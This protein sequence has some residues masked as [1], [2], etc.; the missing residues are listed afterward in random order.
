[1]KSSNAET[2]LILFYFRNAET[3]PSNRSLSFIW[4]NIARVDD[5][6]DK[7]ILALF[8]IDRAF[9]SWNIA[10]LPSNLASQEEDSYGIR[11]E[12]K[13]SDRHRKSVGLQG[14]VAR[15]TCWPEVD[16]VS[17]AIRLYRGYP[18]LSA[19]GLYQLARWMYALLGSSA[20]SYAGFEALD[21]LLSLAVVYEIFSHTFRDFEGLRKLTRAIFLWVA[22]VLA[23][24]GTAV[25]ASVSGAT[26]L[27]VVT[28]LQV[29][30]GTASVAVGSMLYF[31]GRFC[32]SR[33]STLSYIAFC[34]V[35][36]IGLVTGVIANGTFV[37]SNGVIQGIEP[38]CF[39]HAM[40][41]NLAILIW[42]FW[43][44]SMGWERKTDKFLE[45]G[46]LPDLNRAL[47]EVLNR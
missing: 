42:I 31:L 33:R 18:V 11:T 20:G 2:I 35:T 21:A 10:A 3:L 47:M 23:V 4:P 29:L 46:P 15:F 45:T 16:V 25:A 7:E 13:I 30:G 9:A 8:P 40:S 37:T 22:S 38:Y 24:F 6:T 14:C 36:W 19:Y 26:S 43:L 5:F 32:R 1:M 34:G 17:N 12:A 27:R 39:V 44:S 28:G 41:Y